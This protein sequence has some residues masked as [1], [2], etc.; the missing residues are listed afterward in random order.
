MAKIPAKV[1]SRIKEALKRYR[2]LVEQADLREAD[3]PTP[4]RPSERAKPLFNSH[5]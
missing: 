5:E 1:E 4:S 2:S 3:E